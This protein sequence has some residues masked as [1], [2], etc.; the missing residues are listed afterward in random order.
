MSSRSNNNQA[1]E[2]FLSEI[3]DAEAVVR[4]AGRTYTEAPE[5]IH[6]M[7][8]LGTQLTQIKNA[9][10]ALANAPLAQKR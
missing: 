9:G 4:I 6:L 7:D 3:R 1:V 5:L 8:L 2:Q 10:R